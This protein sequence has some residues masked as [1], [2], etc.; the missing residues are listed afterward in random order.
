MT[1]E[2]DAL[3]AF[4]ISG[5]MGTAVALLILALLAE[6]GLRLLHRW[7]QSRKWRYADVVLTSFF[8]QPLFWALALGIGLPLVRRIDNPI[9]RQQRVAF[10]TSLLLISITVIVVRI[11]AGWLKL[12]MAK[13]L[14]A[15]VSILNY[16]INGVA[17]VV[18]LIVALVSLGAPVSIILVTI[19]GSSVG[20]GL[21]FNEP[22]SNLFSGV[23]LTASS[24]LN[25]GDFVRLPSGKEGYIV[26]IEWDV[27]TVRQI[28]ENLVIVPNSVMAKAEIINFQ[29]PEAELLVLADVGVGYDSDLEQVE[30]VTV[31][32]AKAVMQDVSGG[33][34]TSTPFI[35]FRKFAD[36]SIDFT[37][38][39]RGQEF[40]DQILIKHEFIKRL[41][42]RYEEEGIVIPFPIRT[43]HT[44]D[45]DPLTV[46]TNTV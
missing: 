11:I 42:A 38:F 16:L 8:W 36:S 43:L 44:A 21:A 9:I 27:T 4:D 40:H 29:L 17:V 18:V 28:E 12:L 23:Q 22:L 7:T 26:D 45:N 46:A 39:M 13:S 30:R 5:A 24:R 2:F 33:V 14:P 31:E 34:P 3:Q 6:A 37:V 25:P 41:H 32:V 1:E 15:S 35:R 10:L 20:L 19:A